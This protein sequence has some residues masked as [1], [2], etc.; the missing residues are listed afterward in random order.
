MIDQVGQSLEAAEELPRELPGVEGLAA[1]AKMQVVAAEML[2]RKMSVAVAG[3]ARRLE[4]SRQ[5]VGQN[6]VGAVGP[7]SAEHRTAHPDPHQEAEEPY[8]HRMAAQE[9]KK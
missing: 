6:P 2:T 9:P 5:L 8:A 3:L 7:A 1:E 4:C